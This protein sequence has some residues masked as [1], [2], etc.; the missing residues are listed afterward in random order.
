MALFFFNFTKFID[1]DRA[2]LATNAFSLSSRIPSRTK[3]RQRVSLSRKLN[4]RQRRNLK[5]G[6]GRIKFWKIHAIVTVYNLPDRSKSVVRRV[7][8]IADIEVANT[9]N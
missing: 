7:G 1:L 5:N 3:R 8:I 6:H 9:R 4:Y 2:L